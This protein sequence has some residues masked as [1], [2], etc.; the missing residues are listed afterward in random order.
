[1]ADLGLVDRLGRLVLGCGPDNASDDAHRV[2]SGAGPGSH[3]CIPSSSLVLL[4]G[5]RDP[6]VTSPAATLALALAFLGSGPGQEGGP[7]WDAA[8]QLPLPETPAGLDHVRPDL[9]TLRACAREVIFWRDDAAI[10]GKMTAKMTTTG[11]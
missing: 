8:A 4:N 3:P 10:E 7:G 11:R 2:V 9:A 5:A 1:V 6:D